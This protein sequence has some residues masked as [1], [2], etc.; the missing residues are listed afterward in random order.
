MPACRHIY[1]FSAAADR[2]AAGGAGRWLAIAALG[3]D[4]VYLGEGV[5]A[6]S[7]EL[8]GL[9]ASAQR[10]GLT[11]V[12]DLSL[13][14]GDL[15]QLDDY[16]GQG[17]SAFRCR[18]ATALPGDVW[19]RLI[20]AAKATYPHAWFAADALGRPAAE[21]WSLEGAGFDALFNSVGWWNLE[22]RWFIEQMDI[23]RRVA[24]S[25]GCPIAA[26]DGGEQEGAR[27]YLFAGLLSAAVMLPPGLAPS[28]DEPSGL[29]TAIAAIHRLRSDHP[30]LLQTGRLELLESGDPAVVAMIRS[31]ADG[32]DPVAA[33]FNRGS[34]PRR[35]LL[36][37]LWPGLAADLE[38]LWDATPGEPPSGPVGPWLE[39][40]AG[41]VRVLAGRTRRE[42]P[43]ASLPS[44][45]PSAPPPR[46]VI[47]AVAPQIEGA[48]FPIKRVVG[49][50]LKISAD[51]YCDGHDQLAAWACVE[52]GD[53]SG[54][55]VAPMRPVGNDRWEGRV[56]LTKLGRA[57]YTVV[58]WTDPFASWRDE[59]EKRRAAAQPLDVALVEGRALLAAAFERSEGPVRARLETL[60]GEFD[61]L[62]DQSGRA[63][64]LLS[65]V[66]A[67][68]VAQAPDQRDARC[69]PALEAVVDRPAAAFSAWYELFPRSQ[70]D[71]PGRPATFA[72]C[73]RRLPQ[74]QT[75]GFDVL[76]LPPIHPVGA[77]HRKGRNNSPRAA[78]G[79]PGSPYAIGSPAGGHTA[80]DPA[81]GT[82]EDFRGFH[83]AV[84]A[85]GLELALD[86]AIQCSPDHPW[87]RDHPGWFRRR[88]DG[89]IRFAENPPKRYED[90]VNVDF[91]QSDWR[92]LWSALLEVVRFWVGE[93]VRIFRV[94][95]PHTKPFAFWEWLIGE[96]RRD[97]PDV[98]F[99]AEA[100][101]RPKLMRRLAKLGF[102]QS[103]TYFTWRNTVAELTEYLTELNRP[104]PADYL[105]PNFFPTTPDIL[106]LYLQTSGEPGFRIRLVLAATLGGNYGIYSGYEFAEAAALPGREEYADSEKYELKPRDWARRT[107]LQEDLV[108]LNRLRRAR[109]ALFGGGRL[110]FHRAAH[111]AVLFYSRT[112]ADGAAAVLVAVSLDPLRRVDSELWFPLAELGRSE[113]DPFTTTEILSGWR[114]TWLGA[115]QTITLEPAVQPALVWTLP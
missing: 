92:G 31:D 6:N 9:A 41:Q 63:D 25:L 13:R 29:A 90:I 103:Y 99:L 71:A 59:T 1:S 85:H 5:R 27:R 65:G 36:D 57:R 49:D 87:L 55:R 50:W 84:R 107:R 72:D 82:L 111:P 28:S 21:L 58:G 96:V 48:R 43:R 77:T 23:F 52:E 2:S 98:L 30:T 56:R 24:P 10:H 42:H 110:R 86:F 53:A 76:Y 93:G 54:W 94:D 113:R 8:A 19:L 101:T 89:S 75:L 34:A 67:M 108:R 38:E 51:L 47:E 12:V 68:A 105:R 17:V 74:L 4:A 114:Q 69:A 37:R 73:V 60:L 45:S 100:F 70:G 62:T 66:L 15:A 78:P 81:L 3:F 106:P 95:N 14:P 109:A 46:I 20:A 112:S 79:D 97:H 115:R 16:L 33:V 80:I 11:A 7:S 91:A 18:E 104:E 102:S 35:L 32:A 61:R 88:P 44:A 22:D 64:L 40:G 26:P 83:A 39:V